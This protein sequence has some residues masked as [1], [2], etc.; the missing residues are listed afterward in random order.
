MAIIDLHCD[1]MMCLF[2]DRSK[3]GLRHNNLNIDIEKLRAGHYIAQ[4]FALFIDKAEHGDVLE[5][6]LAM[7][8]LFHNQLADNCDSIRLACNWQDVQRNGQDNLLSAF[9]TIEEGGAIKGD[10]AHLRNFYRLGVRLMTLT[11]NYPN[12]L[13]Y[14]NA[15]P[16]YMSQGLTEKG[17]EAVAEMNRLGM[18]IDVSHLSDQGFLDVA[19]LSSRPFVASHS[20]A[21]AVTSHSRNLTDDMIRLLSDKGGI[22]GLNFARQFLGTSPVSRIADMVAHATHIVNVGGEDVLAYGSDFDGID[23][24]IEIAHAGEMG[25]L[26]AALQEAGFTS[27]QLEKFTWRNAAR[28]IQDVLG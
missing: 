19:H 12:E 11:W 14:P 1:T 28:V 23:P 6:C 3:G 16:E 26:T 25:K 10:M 20:N 7:A 17:R 8:D 18:I 9:L 13:G 27:A 15:Q 4:F 22:M 2:E 21:R 24:D 5:R